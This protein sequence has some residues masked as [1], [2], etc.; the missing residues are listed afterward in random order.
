MVQSYKTGGTT[1]PCRHIAQWPVLQEII[2]KLPKIR[3][4]FV[5][6]KFEAQGLEQSSF[7]HIYKW[8]LN[9]SNVGTTSP[10]CLQ[11]HAALFRLSMKGKFDVYLL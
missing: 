6:V 10:F 8:S 9:Y 1:T 11:G 7:E 2:L 4:E 5:F 3:S